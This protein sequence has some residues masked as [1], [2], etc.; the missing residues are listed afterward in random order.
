MPRVFE[1]ARGQFSAFTQ[2]GY[3]LRLGRGTKSPRFFAVDSRNKESLELGELSDGTC[4]QLLL[5]ACMAFAG[6]FRQ[7]STIPLFLDEALDQSDPARSVDIA[8]SL[9]RIAND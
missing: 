3:A 4:A 6:E 8:R 9:G 5:A 2:H 7:G 1:R